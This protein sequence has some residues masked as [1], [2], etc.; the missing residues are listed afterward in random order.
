MLH[1]ASRVCGVQA[2]VMSCAEL[3][4]WARVEGMDR[5]SLPRALWEERTLVK[6]WAM[7]G[8]L[9]LL[10]S[11]ELR[12]WHAGLGTIRRHLREQ[13]WQ[14]HFGIS[15]AQLDELTEAVGA[16]LDG[17]LLTREELAA[18]AGP[19]GAKV[20]E[21]SWGT[22][23]RPAAFT[24][25]LCFAPSVGQRVRF[26]HP[27]SWL[28]AALGPAVSADVATAEITRRFLG[29]FGPA[30]EHDLARWW[31]GGGVTVARQWIKSLSDEVV[32]VDVE[33]TPSW[34]LKAHARQAR[35]L[36]PKQSVRLLPGF[37]PY[38]LAASYH[39]ERLLPGN[40]R[41]K[42]YRPQ[43][44]ISPVLL[45]NGMMEGTWKHAIMGSTVEVTMDPFR[46]QPAWVRQGAREE[47]ERLAQFLG[48]KL[49]WVG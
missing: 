49:K 34:M 23:L 36:A 38:V 24:G 8:T 28:G 37:D 7:R 6:S 16:A 15:L 25:R 10:P 46:R 31:A 9:H 35:D 19:F 30:T 42:V 44:W 45:V 11:S 43:G 48:G 32:P 3:A 33:G 20:A 39:A 27:G 26:T 18:Q 22:M 2:Q 13:Q 47:A 12:M 1:V 29:A 5:E 14:K 4:L 41:A 40:L 17:R 21:S